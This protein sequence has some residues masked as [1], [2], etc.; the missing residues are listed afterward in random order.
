MRGQQ[1]DIRLV[2]LIDIDDPFGNRGVDLGAL[3]G[4][5]TMNTRIAIFELS[6]TGGVKNYVG[7][8]TSA[9]SED[10]MISEARANLHLMLK[11]LAQLS[12]KWL[13]E[14]PASAGTP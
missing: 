3:R 8:P 1:F 9:P 14:P 11:S 6:D 5:V 4:R 12:E 10:A 2:G 13:P 7:I